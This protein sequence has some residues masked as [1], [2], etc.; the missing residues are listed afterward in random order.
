[1]KPYKRLFEKK[2]SVKSDDWDAEDFIKEVLARSKN[3]SANFP[4]VID[5]FLKE[6]Y[7]KDYKTKYGDEI[8]GLLDTILAINKKIGKAFEDVYHS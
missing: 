2:F 4:K 5:T 6:I 8:D 3:N 1:M 7:G